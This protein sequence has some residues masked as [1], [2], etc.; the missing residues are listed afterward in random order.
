MNQSFV[1][2]PYVICGLYTWAVTDICTNSKRQGSET[3]GLWLCQVGEW[4]WNNTTWWAPWASAVQG[5]AHM[6]LGLL[7]PSV[8]RYDT[9]WNVIVW[10]ADS[11][12]WSCWAIWLLVNLQC[13]DA[14]KSKLLQTDKYIGALSMASQINPVHGSSQGNGFFQRAEKESL[15]I[16]T[17]L[18]STRLTQNGVCLSVSTFCAGDKPLREWRVETVCWESYCLT[19]HPLADLLGLL[20]WWSK[21]DKID[22]NM[23]RLMNLD[24][25][26][27]VKYLQ[28]IMDALFNMFTIDSNQ[29]LPQAQLVF[30]GLVNDFCC[31]RSWLS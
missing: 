27:I 25:Q 19:F 1:E 16:E 4:Q 28:D 8:N 29:R 9:P 20:K 17:L 21:P 31:S 26:E 7:L 5:V 13:D 11:C 12:H 18:C 6:I 30:K 10:R 23:Q 3:V 15:F 2:N 22:A 24:G 14:S